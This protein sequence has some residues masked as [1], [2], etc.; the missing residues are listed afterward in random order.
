M[1]NVTTVSKA[2]IGPC[3]QILRSGSRHFGHYVKVRMI[4]TFLIAPSMVDVSCD[5]FVRF[6]QNPD[7]IRSCDLCVNDPEVVAMTYLPVAIIPVAVNSDII[8]IVYCCYV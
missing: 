3:D 7:D 5:W 6:T 2:L 8:Y 4:V 1:V